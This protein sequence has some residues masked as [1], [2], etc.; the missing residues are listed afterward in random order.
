MGKL[1]QEMTSRWWMIMPIW[2]RHDENIRN[3]RTLNGW[4][5]DQK[6]LF[7]DVPY[8]KKIVSINRNLI[9]EFGNKIQN[10]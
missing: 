2:T 9:T 10:K 6:Y 5:D 4:M 1:S 7:V 8:L 3:M